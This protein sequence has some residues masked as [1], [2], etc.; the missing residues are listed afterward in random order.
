M[1]GLRGPR[2][3]HPVALTKSSINRGVA[4]SIF[5]D[6]PLRRKVRCYKGDSASWIKWRE[7]ERREWDRE[8]E[9]ERRERRK[10]EERETRRGV[11]LYRDTSMGI[12]IYTDIPTLRYPYI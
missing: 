2:E 8:G 7:R 6:R 10:E 4:T 12:S 3:V 9:G 1:R 11:P 5:Q